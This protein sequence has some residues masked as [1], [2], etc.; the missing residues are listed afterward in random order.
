MTHT[1]RYHVGLN[2]EIVKKGMSHHVWRVGDIVRF[3]DTNFYYRVIEVIRCVDEDN[4]NYDRVNYKVELE[5][6]G[7]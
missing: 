2:N 5:R 7:E 3:D 1:V 6:H 4:S